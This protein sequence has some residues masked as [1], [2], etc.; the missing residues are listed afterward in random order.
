MF[1]AIGEFVTMA[2]F[3]KENGSLSRE[4]RKR[5]SAPVLRVYG[6]LQNMTQAQRGGNREDSNNDE[7]TG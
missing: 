1:L 3:E 6:N 7:K 2:E 5:Y 4:P